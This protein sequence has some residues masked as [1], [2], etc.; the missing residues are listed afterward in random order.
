MMVI[1]LHAWDILEQMEINVPEMLEAQNV[2]QEI[3]MKP[4]QHIKLQINAWNG[5][6]V[7]PQMEKNVLTLKAVVQQIKVL[8]L[9]VKDLLDLMVIVKE[10]HLQYQIVY[11][12]YALMIL[13]QLLMMIAK[14]HN[15]IVL[16]QAKVVW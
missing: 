13:L 7:V 14:K 16:R 11:Q 3:V 5:K 4:L 6:R 9:L 10:L 2:D 8:Q 1:T 15:L 12:S